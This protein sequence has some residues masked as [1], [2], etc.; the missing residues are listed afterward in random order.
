MPT[1]QDRAALLSNF[2]RNLRESRLTQSASTS[3]PQ[4]FGVEEDTGAQMEPGGS[5]G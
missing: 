5:N 4:D 1:D 2:M 3:N